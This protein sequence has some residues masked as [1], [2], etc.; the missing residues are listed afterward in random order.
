MTGVVVEVGPGTVRRFD[1]EPPRWASIALASIDDDIALVDECPIAVDE[2]WHDV[3]HGAMADSLGTAVLVYPSWWAPSRREVISRAARGLAAEIVLADRTSVLRAIDPGSPVTTVEIDAEFVCVCPPGENTRAESRL[4]GDDS[5]ADAVAAKIPP[6]TVVIIDAPAKVNGSEAL[7]RAIA[8]RLRTTAA[9]VTLASATSVCAASRR[10]LTPPPVDP[11]KA[12]GTPLG[13][14]RAAVA[15]IG[16]V[17]S[18]AV[19]GGTGLV[20]RHAAGDRQHG[21]PSTMLVEGRVELAVPTSWSAER[22]TAGSGSARLQLVSPTD[23]DLAIHL[24]QSVVLPRRSLRDEALFLQSA[25][26]A[27]PFGVFTD[28][29]GSARIGAKRVVAYRELRK[30]RR[31][32]WAVL[33]DGG[34]RIAIGC[35]SAPGREAMVREVCGQ[36]IESAHAVP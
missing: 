34:L 4:A 23:R 31:I 9:Q 12:A 27:Q 8:E 20:A 30:D 1:G 28:F 10:L 11:G 33:I 3:L 32:A 13:H 24:T 2:L 17:A 6:Q 15:L 7:G 29:D 21:G 36:A 14:R 25:L 18:V 26:A 19:L 35:E 16:T 5:A 22:V